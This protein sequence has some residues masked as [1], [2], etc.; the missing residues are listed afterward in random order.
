M[1]GHSKWSQIKH[2]KGITDKKK[3]QIFSKLSRL[4]TLAARKGTDPKINSELARAIEHARS[5]NMP[6]DNIERAIK[7]VADKNQ[8]QLE[9]LSV[10]ALGPGGIALQIKAITDNRN[11]TL[12]EIRKILSDFEAKMVQPGSI[13]WLF[14]QPPVSI[15]NAELQNRIDKLFEA[16]DDQDEVEDIVS[17][18]SE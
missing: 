17:N 6:G 18:L 10:E 1:S 12:S 11:R 14:D 15:E 5:F 16:L 8:A 13:R 9:E 2:K 4:I 3:S 7:K